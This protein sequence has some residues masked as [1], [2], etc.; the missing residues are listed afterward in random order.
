MSR[1]CSGS[2]GISS[3]EVT[4][5]P[6]ADVPQSDVQTRSDLPDASLTAGSVATTDTA[7]VC[8]PGYATDLRPRGTLWLRLKEQAYRRYS[9]PR[10]HHSY[11][12]A[13]GHRHP[14]YEIDHLIPLEIGGAP[15]DIRNLWPQTIVEAKAKDK[16]ENALHA[17]V[18]SGQMPI[19]EAQAA[20]AKNWETAVPHQ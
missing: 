14:A 6:I 9:I 15:D 17:L 10:G 2:S 8:T 20:I 4:I 19:T 16:V 3:T 7:K 5:A 11:I 18:C 1:H 12:D 13:A